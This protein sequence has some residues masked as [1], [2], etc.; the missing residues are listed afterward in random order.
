MVLSRARIE[1]K[2]VVRLPMLLVVGH[3]STPVGEQRRRTEST[4]FIRQEFPSGTV[5]I[6]SCQGLLGLEYDREP[7]DL[8]VTSRELHALP[9]NLDGR[10]GTMLTERQFV[11]QR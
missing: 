7:Y 9:M 10:I 2:E 1:L 11:E 6:K 4:E 8:D 5:P 3:R